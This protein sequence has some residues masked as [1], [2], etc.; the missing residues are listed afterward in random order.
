[1]QIKNKNPGLSFDVY[2]DAH[3]YI[4]RSTTTDLFKVKYRFLGT[5]KTLTNLEG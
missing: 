3:K 5:M 2:K 1:M 4:F